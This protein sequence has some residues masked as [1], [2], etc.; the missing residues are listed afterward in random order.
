VVQ[1]VAGWL[2]Q[3]QADVV[4]AGVAEARL[5]LDPGIGFGKT[6]SHNW[7]LLRRQHE[8]IALGRPLL[9]GWSRKS[10]LGSL[11][12]RPVGERLPASLAAALAA[13]QHGARVLRVHDV[14]ATA[15]A[16]KVWAAAGLPAMPPEQQRPDRP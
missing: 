9:V 13:V 3:R 7:E 4:A 15:D 11:T 2:R 6:A 16:L 14:A 12:G 5:V 1:Q 8:L 10:S